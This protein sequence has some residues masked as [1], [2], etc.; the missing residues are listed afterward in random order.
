[1]TQIS[2]QDTFENI[3]ELIKKKELVFFVGAGISLSYKGQKGLISGWDL[4][5]I[6]IEK[7]LESEN[8]K[9][10]EQLDFKEIAQKVIWSSKGSR[11]KLEEFLTQTFDDPT[12]QPL[13]CHLELSKVDVDI[14]S[15]NYDTLIE[16][17][18]RKKNKR[19]TTLYKDSQLPSY[20]SPLIIKIHGCITEPDSCVITEDD[21]F[22]W[23]EKNPSL[24]SLLQTIFVTKS[25]CFIGYSLSDFN[26]KLLLY[27]IRSKFGKFHRQ[28]FIVTHKEPNNNYN[29]EYLQKS[30][31]ITPFIS[32]ATEFLEGL[33]YELG[34]NE[35]LSFQD[36]KFRNEYFQNATSSSFQDFI[37]NKIAKS[38]VNNECEQIIL[39]EEVLKIVNQKLD[40]INYPVNELE[41]FLLV[42]KGQFIKGGER[43]GNEKIIIGETKRDV[44]F[45]KFQVT[46]FEYKKFLSFVNENGDTNFRHKSQPLEKSHEPSDNFIGEMPS[47]YFTNKKYD[48]YPVVNIDWWDAFAYCKWAGGRLPY[49]SEWEKASRGIDGRKYH[50]GN[51]FRKDT[52]NTSESGILKTVPVDYYLDYPTPYG[53]IGM[54][55]NSWEWC[56][57]KMFDFDDSESAPRIVKG[58]SFSRDERRSRCAFL[59]CHPP[60]ARYQT[61]GF[62]LVKDKI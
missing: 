44:F 2:S 30:L 8:P 5:N 59:N 50:N 55:G 39:S 57:D 32:D 33:N 22:R 11:Y 18:F 46:N 9:D 23:F 52:I 14:I 40:V 60:N 45:S 34:N 19:P 42:P 31:G 13:Q 61:R 58:G 10:I 27:N 20:S 41:N 56:F 62:R 3:L 6:L 28:S 48:N 4:R 49:E 24:V 21:Y 47:D 1:M 51:T 29:F 37:S 12:I 16:Q 53:I 26:F 36:E 43:R 38:I 15:T 35:F 25:I 17:S 54:N 7:F